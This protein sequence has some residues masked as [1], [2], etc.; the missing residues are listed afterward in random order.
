MPEVDDA[1]RSQDLGGPDTFSFRELGELAFATLKKR[2]R[3]GRVPTWLLQSAATA[4]RPFNTN[5]ATFAQMFALAGTLDAV[6]PEQGTHHLPNHFHA[7]A[8]TLAS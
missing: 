5:A 7:V 3:F 1:P 4:M 8:E 2:P 6:A